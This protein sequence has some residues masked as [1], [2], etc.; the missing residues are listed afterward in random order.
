[1]KTKQK[2]KGNSSNAAN[3]KGRG[4]SR[5]NGEDMCADT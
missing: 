3:P 5:E 4:D 2:N 1:M